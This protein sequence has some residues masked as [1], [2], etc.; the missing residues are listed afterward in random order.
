MGQLLFRSFLYATG[1]T[2]L[3]AVLLQV[4]SA[5]VMGSNN[6]KMQSDSINAGGGLSNSAT[7]RLEDTAG[8]IATGNSTST[9]F[10]LKA[11]YQQMQEVFLSLSAMADVNLAPNLG[12]VSGGTS[13]GSTTF[14]VITDNPA[15]YTV[16][17]NASTSPAM[18]SGSNSIADYVPAG[19]VPDFLF[20]TDPTEAH[21]AYSP[22][23]VDVALRF[24]DAGSVCGVAGSDTLNRCF[25]GLSTTPVEIV[26]RTSSNHPAGATTSVR[27]T[28]GIGGN[29]N[30]PEGVYV[31]TTTI[32]ALPL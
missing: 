29:I 22:E 28:V 8:E 27:F 3:V 13:T 21:L 1:T 12:G 6:Y 9:S 18:Q 2:L 19:G 30:V 25:D 7:Y 17:I 20:T 14:T 24:Q 4:G 15:G 31:A 10:N 26:R 23:G 5:Q 11:G 16:T 32:T